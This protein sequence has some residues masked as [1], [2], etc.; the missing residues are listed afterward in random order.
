M[1]LRDEAIEGANLPPG[2]VGE[3][4]GGDWEVCEP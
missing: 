4:K 2:E 1:S 3:R